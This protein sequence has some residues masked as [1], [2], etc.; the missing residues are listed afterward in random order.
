MIH[1]RS[2]ARSATTSR[3]SLTSLLRREL[4]LLMHSRVCQ[5]GEGSLASKFLLAI[6]DRRLLKPYQ[7]HHNPVERHIQCIT[8]PG[9]NN[10]MNKKL[11][12]PS[13]SP[14]NSHQ[15]ATQNIIVKS[16]SSKSI[17][18]LSIREM[19]PCP[20]I[21]WRDGAT[22]TKKNGELSQNKLAHRNCHKIK[23]L[24]RNLMKQALLKRARAEKSFSFPVSCINLPTSRDMRVAV[25]A[26]HQK[27]DD[28][29]REKRCDDAIAI[30]EG[31]ADVVILIR[32]FCG[33]SSSTWQVLSFVVVDTI[34]IL[35]IHSELD[36]WCNYSCQ[37][38]SVNFWEHYKAYGERCKTLNY[39]EHMKTF[40]QIDISL[41]C[42][43]GKTCSLAFL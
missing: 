25:R 32:M 12:P 14:I 3:S 6:I 34:P 5:Y 21:M 37:L 9:I 19:T 29:E 4:F 2:T 35:C 38:I 41:L 40:D 28:E 23:T 43:T 13:R 1:S 27:E 15:L 33:T 22:T 39:G 42:L 10:Q 18:A 16:A 24:A 30:D 36:T 11:L 8:P 31:K 7:Q 17:P 20:C 26:F